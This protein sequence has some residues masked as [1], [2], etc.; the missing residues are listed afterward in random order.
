VDYFVI[1]YLSVGGFLGLEYNS[2]PAGSST[3]FSLGPR[4]GYNI[5]FSRRFSVWPKVGLSIGHTSQDIDDEL[6]GAVGEDESNTSLQLNLFL[7]V[8]FHPVEHFFLGLGPAFDLDLTGD[9][10]ATILAV[11]LTLGGWLD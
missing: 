7:P 8:M 1:D 2:T 10:K 6:A 11:R 5:P 4:V 9:D 3:A